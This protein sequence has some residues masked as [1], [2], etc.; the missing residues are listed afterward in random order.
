[1]DN[2]LVQLKHVNFD[3]FFYTFKLRDKPRDKLERNEYDD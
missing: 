2:N 3:V 1:M